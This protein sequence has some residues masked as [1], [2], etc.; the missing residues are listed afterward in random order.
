[1]G[2]MHKSAATLP[3]VGDDLIP[4]EVSSLRADGKFEHELAQSAALLDWGKYPYGLGCDPTVAQRKGDT[5]IGR[6]TGIERIARTGMWRLQ[7]ADREPENLNGQ[8]EEILNRVTGDLE[9]WRALTLRFRVEFFCGLFL[10]GEN[11]GLAISPS[12]LLA[13]GQ[14]GIELALDVYGYGPD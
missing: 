3:V 7:S 1:M 13:L 12:V 10:G 2:R 8:I 11:E 14:R 6:K 9:T 5:L 4:A